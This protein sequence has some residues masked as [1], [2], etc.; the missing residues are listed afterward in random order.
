[1]EIQVYLN[2][3]FNNIASEQLMGVREAAKRIGRT[4]TELQ[5][6]PD[7]PNQQPLLPISGYE[8]R[9]GSQASPRWD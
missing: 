9:C 1:M 6:H 5:F 3:F 2:R 7:R 8:Y 4:Y